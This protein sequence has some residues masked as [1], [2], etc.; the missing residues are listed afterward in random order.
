M[1]RT[2]RPSFIRM[3]GSVFSECV[4]K[5]LSAP[6]ANIVFPM[7]WS[8]AQS[9][10]CIGIRTMIQEQLDE[11]QATSRRGSGLEGVDR[12]RRYSYHHTIF[13]YTIDSIIYNLSPAI[14]CLKPRV[15][16]TMFRLLPTVSPER[17]EFP[18]ANHL[19]VSL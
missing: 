8:L 17:T 13:A 18:G 3:S 1:A 16:S 6:D 14:H 19:E 10:L 5:N 11:I 4:S 2:D 7:E 12:S 15:R 9:V